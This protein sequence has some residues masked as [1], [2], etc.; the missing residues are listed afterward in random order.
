M[1]RSDLLALDVDELASLTNRGTVKRAIRELESGQPEFSIAENGK[2]LVVS[3]SDGTTC[4]FPAD[5]PIKDAK[6]SSGLVGISRHIVRSV[7]AYQQSQTCNGKAPETAVESAAI[8]TAWDPGKFSDEELQQHFGKASITRARKRFK[9]GIL[10]DLSRGRKPT[11]KFLHDSCTIRFPVPRDLRYAAGDCEEKLLST[12]IPQAVWAFRELAADRVS[13]LVVTGDG[14]IDLPQK[15]IDQLTILLGELCGSGIANL[16]QTWTQRLA[17][18][19]D[20][21]IDSNLVW[22]AS[23]CEELRLQVVGYREQDARF[24]PL[25]VSRLLGELKARLRVIQN[26]SNSIPHALICGSKSSSRTAIKSTRLVA[27]G[28]DV[29][30]MENHVQFR[31]FLQDCETGTVLVLSR[32]I[33]SRETSDDPAKS[34]DELASR[35]LAGGIS[36]ERFAQSLLLLGS[37]KRTPT[38]DLILPVGAGK[39]TANPQSFLWEDLKPPFAVE[40]FDQLRQRL[41][42]LPPDW[43][44]PRRHAE[45]LHVIRIKKIQ[46]ATFDARTQRM[47]ATVEDDEESFATLSLAYHSQGRAGFDQFLEMAESRGSEA[48]FVCG[49]VRLDNREL[50]ISPIS[51]VF[52]VEGERRMILPWLAMDISQ[53]SIPESE[54]ELVDEENPIDDFLDRLGAQV[55]DTL[56]AGWHN[57]D[58]REWEALLDHGKS[59]GFS[60][61][62]K[63]VDR[64]AADL[65][66]R[67]ERRIHESEVAAQE[68]GELCVYLRL[69]S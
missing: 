27:V 67:M 64:I 40:S 16:P 22:P 26:E 56:L 10:A 6:C 15:S 7:L 29:K 66:Q 35:V 1:K 14:K 8:G 52:E 24:D 41:E 58:A 53:A 38:D 62:L 17:R 13:G 11:A 34:F 5:K 57:A 32:T 65:R 50:V 23:L 31:I 21:L 51:L 55:S 3:W 47:S 4:T 28:L 37:G 9:A 46:D 68:L 2:E 20:K 18:V 61:S 44:R 48:L 45:N 49:H 25:E 30:P 39:F 54:P 59:I 69:M 63:P 19:E 43:L 36:I 33:A 12:W 60:R 42:M